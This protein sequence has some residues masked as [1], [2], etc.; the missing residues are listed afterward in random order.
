VDFY[1]E[2]TPTPPPT[3]VWRTHLP[4]ILKFRYR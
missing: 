4:V 3:V 2:P 1:F